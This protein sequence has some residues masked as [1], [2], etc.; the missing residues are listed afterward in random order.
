[1]YIYQLYRIHNTSLESA[2]FG[3]DKRECE[4]LEFIYLEYLYQVR[5]DCSSII[6]ITWLYFEIN[7][8]RVFVNYVNTHLKAMIG[9]VYTALGESGVLQFVLVPQLAL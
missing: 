7:E 1:L 6:C 4:C 9:V 8:G 2:Y 3:L 5:Q